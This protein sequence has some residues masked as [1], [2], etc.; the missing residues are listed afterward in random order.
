VEPDAEQDEHD[1]ETDDER[2]DAERDDR[3]EQ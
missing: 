2:G 3:P 1:T